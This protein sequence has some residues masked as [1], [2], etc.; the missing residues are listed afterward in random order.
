MVCVPVGT[1]F[2]LFFCVIILVC[3]R[4]GYM[5]QDG[6]CRRAGPAGRPPCIHDNGAR[7]GA[8][9]LICTGS[10][11]ARRAPPVT[12][13][14]DKQRGGAGATER[15]GRAA[16]TC[17][18]TG[19]RARRGRAAAHAP[20][21]GRRPPPRSLQ[22]PQACTR[23]RAARRAG[24]PAA[25]SHCH[26]RCHSRPRARARGRGRARRT[27]QNGRGR[28]GGGAGAGVGA[29]GAPRAGG[30]GRGAGR[31]GRGPTGAGA[32]A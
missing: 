6:M 30:G 29:R 25:R 5:G 12:A 24:R 1:C 15:R 20:N 10:T 26:C 17:I 11:P 9:A 3:R 8:A 21:A 4:G 27:P 23:R 22:R 13:C 2:V 18:T 16:T 19:R 14:G 28:S 32:G 7:C 31:G